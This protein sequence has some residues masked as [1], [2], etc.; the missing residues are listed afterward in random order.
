MSGSLFSF[1]TKQFNRIFP[2]YI[3]IESDCNIA[4]L[5]DTIAAEKVKKGED[6]YDYF[7]VFLPHH[8]EHGFHHLKELAGQQIILSYK[9]DKKNV[10]QGQVEF[11]EEQNCLLFAGAPYFLNDTLEGVLISGNT[12]E[13]ASL[14]TKEAAAISDIKGLLKTESKRKK[15][16]RYT[17][18][19]WEFALN[20]SG[21]GI[22]Q[23]DFSNEDGV[24]FT[25]N[26]IELGESGNFDHIRWIGAIHPDDVDTVNKAFA[27][28]ISG[29][30]HQFNVEHRLMDQ[31]GDYKYFVTRG[32]IVEWDHHNPS[33]VI[34]TITNIDQQKQLEFRIKET[35]NRL[36]FLIK[37]LESGV[38]MEGKDQR[39]IMVNE[40]FCKFLNIRESP[41]DLIGLNYTA[42]TKQ[43]KSLY[44]HPEEAVKRIHEILEQKKHIANEVV[45]LADGR[46]FK[47]DFIPILLEGKYEGHLWQYTD[48]T[49]QTIAKQQLEQQKIFY[50]N[51][52]NNIPADIVAYN[53]DHEY[54]FINPTAIKDQ[55]LRA[56]LIGKRDEDYCIYKNKPMTVAQERRIL[57]NKVLKSKKLNSWVERVDARDGSVEYFLRNMYPVL[58]NKKEVTQVIGF[59][60]NITESKKIEDQLKINEKRYRDLFDYSQAFICTHDLNGKL[61]T[62]NP[63]F[64]ELLGYTE[65]ELKGRLLPDFFPKDDVKNFYTEYLEHV[66]NIGHAKGVF[67]V[68]SKDKKPSFILYKNFKVEEET[69]DPYIIGFA[70]DITDRI[71]TEKE[72][73]ATKKVTEAA[74]KAKEIF[75]ANMSHEIRTPMTGILGIVNILT[76]TD[77]DEEQRKFTKLISESANNLLTI[78]NDVLDIEKIAAGKLEL[79]NIPFKIED[80]VFTTL[81]SFQFKAEDKNINLLLNSSLPDGL[82]VIGDPY[83]LSQILN[84]LLSNALKF[85]LDGEISINMDCRADDDKVVTIEIQVQDTGIGIQ[86][87][88]LS[89]IFNPFEQ[90]SADT[91]RKYGGTGLGLTICKNLVE[92]QGGHIGVKSRVNEGTMF[93]FHIPYEKGDLSMLPNESKEDI[94]FKDLESISILVAED[95]EL[96]Q[97]LIKHIL[98]SWGCM[99]NVVG[100][101]KEAVDRVRKNHYDLVLMDI[102]MPEMDGITATKII[103]TLNLIERSVVDRSAI[104]KKIRTMNVKD[105]S[106]I[107]II[108][109]TANAL[110]GD[111]QRYLD[112]GMDG[113]ITKP[114][115]EEKLFTVINRVIKSN[116]KLRFRIKAD[117]KPQEDMPPVEASEKLFDLALVNTIGKNDAD[118][119]RKLVT[120]FLD[121][122]P[123]NLAN[124]ETACNEKNYEVISRVAHKMKS[125]IDLFGIHSLKYTIRKLENIV[126]GH[127]N[128]EPNLEKVKTTLG[129]VFEQMRELEIEN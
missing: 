33:L 74:H 114:Y 47:R 45:E 36:F 93:T 30:T 119:T 85:T 107:P 66:I 72:L 94:N 83:R 113:Y 117:S 60:L 118:F 19:F 69:S 34:G 100:N 16:S 103:R 6:L 62:A 78:V 73:L 102:Q 23:Y 76:K 9:K 37:N 42:A 18:H 39:I 75:L 61:L 2:Y 116:D 54:L 99:V 65:D 129:E 63:A 86:P 125:N 104:T 8:V 58:N 87:E 68:I 124:L 31:N 51:V 82:V 3:I 5:S 115:T 14:A 91:T 70:Q 49:E 97:F 50:E 92:M 88:K 121:N 120:A 90:A 26:K 67:C 71:E 44:R 13:L 43:S 105:K 10:L 38:V 126:E 46:Y 127:D 28:Y 111:G 109:L 89:A 81:Q 80:K 110:K 32:I 29:K 52:L 96:N 41:E 21:D 25:H 22:W 123:V 128:T 112:I 106:T 79:E 77:L 40:Q 35:A 59:G 84:N 95:V 122:M 17:Q 98:E 11:L 24:N 64:C 12:Q 1:N 55:E 4:A 7:E 57:F 56:W 27:D 15:A 48:I 108:A 53:P 20:G 101:G